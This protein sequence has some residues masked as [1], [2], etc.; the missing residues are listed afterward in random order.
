M[1]TFLDEPP[2]PL[3]GGAEPDGAEPGTDDTDPRPSPRPDIEMPPVP[4]RFRTARRNFSTFA[5]SGGSDRGALRRAVSDYVRSGTQ[6]SANAVRRMGAS[7]NAGGA[8]LG[9]FR[10]FQRDGVEASLRRL[11]LDRLIGRPAREIFVGLTDVICQNGGPID[12]GVA[13]DAWLETVADLDQFGIDDLNALNIDQIQE[14]F[15]AFIVHAVETR[16]FQDIGANGLDIASDLTAIEAFEAQFRDYIRRSVRDSFSSDL[17]QL[18]DLSDQQ[19]RTIVD[20]TYRDAWDL[21]DAW[22]ISKNETP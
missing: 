2:E 9:M 14:V 1:P 10:G 18:A 3:P 22:G 5:R 21:L 15:L 13:R 20:R 11:N 8:V 7:R 12:E 6:G 4:A 17:R 19:I 16:L